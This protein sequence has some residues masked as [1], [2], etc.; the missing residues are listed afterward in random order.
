[1]SKKNGLRVEIWITIIALVGGIIGMIVDSNAIAIPLT[2]Y[3]TVVFGFM[4]A[5]SILLLKN[6]VSNLID[7]KLRI[8]QKL[9]EIRDSQ[10]RKIALEQLDEYKHMLEQLARGHAEIPASK[11]FYTLQDR[12][13]K[14]NTTVRATHVGLDVRLVYG[15]L[16]PGGPAQ[17]YDANRKAIDRGIQIERIFVFRR[18]DIFREGQLMDDRI[19]EILNKQVSAG[20]QVIIAFVEDLS[21]LSLV[22]DY[23][24]FDD[25][26]VIAMQ[27]G[28]GLIYQMIL[29]KLPEDIEQY[30]SRFNALK[31]LGQLYPAPKTSSEE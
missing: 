14:A 9:D 31:A 25:D 3:I 29:K 20:I 19:I 27:A 22:E 6:E 15:W 26:T 24:I 7:D 2:T 17:W 12:L 5:S 10:L 30:A 18:E 23:I 1:M 16:E 28:W 11:I 13:E 8:Y 4:L 21:D